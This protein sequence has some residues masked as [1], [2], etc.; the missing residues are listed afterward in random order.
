MNNSVNYT[1]YN[2]IQS[3]SAYISYLPLAIRYI[4]G[5]VCEP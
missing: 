1:F 5:Y 2:L 3:T 4:I